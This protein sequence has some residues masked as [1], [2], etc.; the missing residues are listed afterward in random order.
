M[1]SV[2]GKRG[3]CNL[4]RTK[5]SIMSGSPWATCKRVFPS[6]DLIPDRLAGGILK[7][8]LGS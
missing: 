4:C 6:T 2:S 8:A 1:L 3:G 7:F 5:K